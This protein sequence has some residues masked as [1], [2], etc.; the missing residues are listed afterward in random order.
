MSEIK[1]NIF[2]ESEYADDVRTARPIGREIN[3][4]E[5]EDVATPRP[6][7]EDGFH[8]KS[9]KGLLASVLNPLGSISNEEIDANAA[10][11]VASVN[12]YD[13]R[14]TAAIKQLVEALK[15]VQEVADYCDP[16]FQVRRLSGLSEAIRSALKSYEEVTATLRRVNPSE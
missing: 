8:I 6:W 13:P 9:S 5:V 4:E 16:Q 7:R 11:I 1:R 10:L 2:D 15:A 14:H 12:S 3:S